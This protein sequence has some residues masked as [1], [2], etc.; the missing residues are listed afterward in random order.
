MNNNQFSSRFGAIAAT[1]GGAIGLGNVWRFPY[2]M[3]ENGGGAFL[4]IYLGFV[5]LL[6]IP[7]M[8]T[9]FVIGRSTHKGAADAIRMLA[10]GTKL[11]H[12]THLGAFA[13]LLITGFYSVVAGWILCYLIGSFRGLFL[14]SRFTNYTEAFEMMAASPALTLVSSLAVLLI[15]SL[16]MMRGV[17]RG[18]ERICN[19]L[20]PLLFLSLAVLCIRACTLKGAAEGLQFMFVPNFSA[21]TGKVLLN[22]LGQAFFSLALGCFGLV[23]YASYFTD[24][25]R[26]NSTAFTIA[27]LDTLVAIMAGVM[28]FPVLFTAGREAVAGPELLFVAMPET[29]A[30]MSC[31]MLWSFFF[32][33]LLFF[34]AISSLFCIN[35]IAI[36]FAENELHL[37]RKKATAVQTLVAALFVVLASLSF[38]LLSDFQP[39]GRTFFDWFDYLASN[40][41]MPLGG[42]FTAVFVGWIM[43]RDVVVKELR[44]ERHPLRSRL[45]F[46]LLRF[47]AP[48]AILL[49]FLAGLG[50]F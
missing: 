11:Q 6:G 34:A 27:G 16:V 23:T 45:F 7:V 28:I 10:P 33:V 12:V 38:N 20:M 40:W 5:L 26:L 3:A 24:E 30:T 50:V 41:I 22:A 17:Q 19:I 37:G 31:G 9:E 15:T 4:L 14:P 46:F 29:F 47:L 1:V 42:L 48:V 25:T 8:L 21:I 18:I 44:L 32:F 39:L 2:E 13:S 49:V 36:S 43:K 35:E